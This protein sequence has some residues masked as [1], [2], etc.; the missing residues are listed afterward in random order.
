M[1]LIWSTIWESTLV[2]IA[3]V[4]VEVKG[5]LL[6]TWSKDENLV[7]AVTPTKVKLVGTAYMVCRSTIASIKLLHLFC[8]GRQKSKL[9]YKS[10]VN[11]GQNLM[12]NCAEN[13]F[14]SV[15]LNILI[16]ESWKQITKP[17]VLFDFLPG[18]SRNLCDGGGLCVCDTC[19]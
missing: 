3:K 12:C 16:Y 9:K 15:T 10:F 4:F 17:L 8:W 1:C 18:G 19:L 11:T 5:N 14:C 2:S 13:I 7:S 6:P